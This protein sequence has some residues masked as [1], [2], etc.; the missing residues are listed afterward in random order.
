MKTQTE[1]KAGM[2]FYDA[3]SGVHTITG[4]TEKYIEHEWWDE[5]RRRHN[6]GCVMLRKTF[7]KFLAR[8]IICLV[9]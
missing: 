6:T 5:Q 3:Y 4:V 1:I 2:K 9:F 7:D 8:N